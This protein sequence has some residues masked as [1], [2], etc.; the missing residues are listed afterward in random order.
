MRTSC[1]KSG[2]ITSPVTVGYYV[3][4]HPVCRS[5][6]TAAR[7][8]RDEAVNISHLARELTLSQP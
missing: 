4:P 3:A 1:A 6:A 2:R 8:I 7:C 5:V